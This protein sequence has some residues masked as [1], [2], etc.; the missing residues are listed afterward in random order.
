M[1]IAIGVGTP[2][3]PRMKIWADRKIARGL[4]VQLI[5]LDY[6]LQLMITAQLPTNLE[7]ESSSILPTHPAVSQHRRLH[8]IVLIPE[9]RLFREVLR[10]CRHPSKSS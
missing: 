4:Y 6:N 5:A 1:P 8:M 2:N 7:L 9:T 3:K 10:L